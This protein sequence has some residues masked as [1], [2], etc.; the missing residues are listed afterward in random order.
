MEPIAL[1][2]IPEPVDGTRTIFTASV[3]GGPILEGQL[4]D[5]PDLVCGRCRTILVTRRS[6]NQVYDIV[7]RCPN[8]SSFNEAI[9]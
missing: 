1:T 6:L 8:C 9:V 5:V 2:I 7:F 4:L 3:Q